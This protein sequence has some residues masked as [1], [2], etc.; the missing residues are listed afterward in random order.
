MYVSQFKLIW[1]EIVAEI[2]KWHLRLTTPIWD[3]TDTGLIGNGSAILPPFA[4]YCTLALQ[5]CT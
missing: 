3:G 4:Q 1:A 2:M 5:I